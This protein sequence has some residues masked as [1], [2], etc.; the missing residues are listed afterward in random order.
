[1]NF[2]TMTPEE[3]AEEII[4]QGTFFQEG[5]H[6]YL[7]FGEKVYRHYAKREAPRYRGL[8]LVR[9][10]EPYEVSVIEVLNMPFDIKTHVKS[11]LKK[12]NISCQK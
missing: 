3:I 6:Y 8:V 10:G 7:D 2:N 4:T 9:K 1:M 12:E 5:Q 11:E